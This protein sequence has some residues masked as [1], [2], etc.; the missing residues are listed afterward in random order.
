MRIATHLFILVACI[1]VTAACR[2]RIVATAELHGEGT[3]EAHFQSTGAPLVLWADTD[4]TWRGSNKKSRFPANYEIDVL[5]GGLSVGHVSCDTK[6]F[7]TAICGTHISNGDLQSGDCEL[8][9]TCTLPAIPSGDTILRVKG[10]PG[11][12]AME[13]KKMSINVR[14]K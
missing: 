11:K 10:V 13:V 2:G 5:S 14:N 1:L 9:L 8:K 3:A 4:G 7:P 6:D 12:Y